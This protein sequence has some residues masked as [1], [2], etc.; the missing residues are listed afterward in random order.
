VKNASDYA[1]RLGLLIKDLR[2]RADV[3]PI[4][5]DR[6]ALQQIIHGFLTWESSHNQAEP[7][8]ARI[9]KTMVD[10]NDLRVTDPAELVELIGTRYA[11]VEE[12]VIRLLRVLNALYVREHNTQLPAITT[13]GKREVRTYLETLDGMAPY[14]AATVCLLILD[15]HAMPVDEQLLNRLKSDHIVA[16]DASIEQAQSFL[17]QNVAAAEGIEVYFLLR[18][19]VERPIKA[20]LPAPPRSMTPSAP[21]TT[22][23]PTKKAPTKKAPTKKTVT[24][25]APTKKVTTKKAVTKKAPTKKITTKKSKTRRA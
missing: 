5:P 11:R 7:A 4:K 20:Q 16:D 3:T 24:K 13:M 6:D 19:Y 22:K 21:A 10:Y 17:E 25:K 14:V 12:R 23:K 1:K 2:K 8:Y 18:A 15:A 9:V